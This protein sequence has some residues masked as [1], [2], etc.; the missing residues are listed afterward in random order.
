MFDFGW[1]GDGSA[2]TTMILSG[3]E[4]FKVRLLVLLGIALVGMLFML[5]EVGELAGYVLQGRGFTAPRE[6]KQVHLP[7]IDRSSFVSPN[8]SHFH[9]LSL[10]EYPKIYFVDPGP[11]FNEQL[12]QQVSSLLHPQYFTE[13]VL[14]DILKA[15]A[16]AVDNAE[17]A[18]LFFVDAY[19]AS[20]S[21]LPEVEKRMASDKKQFMEAYCQQLFDALFNSSTWTRYNGRD[22]MI[23]KVSPWPTC[24]SAATERGI[25]WI[26]LASNEF[27][28][29]K[30][31]KVGS[32]DEAVRHVTIPY[33]SPPLF[34]NTQSWRPAFG[35]QRRYHLCFYGTVNRFLPRKQFQQEL[36]HLLARQPELA[37]RVIFET[38]THREFNDT[39]M[40]DMY[41]QSV[42]CPIF[43]GDSPHSRRLFTTM[44]LGC[45]PVLFSDH[46]QVPFASRLDW[47]SFVFDFAQ[48]SLQE[49]A[50]SSV[51]EYLFQIP[52]TEI[53]AKQK[54]LDAVRHHFAY[55]ETG[56][57]PGDAVDMILADLSDRARLLKQW[58]RNQP[59]QQRFRNQ[60]TLQ[61]LKVKANS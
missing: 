23:I 24:F 48:A 37:G 8:R 36:E 43:P 9:A 46:I 58:N 40:I 6:F 32:W 18:D 7:A 4:Q 3:S 22:H 42:L 35:V 41:S 57:E 27:G 47:S 59:H 15:S 31:K 50:P 14:R 44:L 60:Q 49:E 38:M 55:H 61:L 17:E 25:S 51:V 10:E 26:Q 11:Q 5:T 53:S 12:R 56:I 21:R 34:T 1:S 20:M 54:A 33:Y 39:A 13:Y 45:V 30:L 29:P 16:F 19:I 2:L 52:Q 28:Y